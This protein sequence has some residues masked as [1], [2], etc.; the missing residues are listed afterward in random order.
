MSGFRIRRA[1]RRDLGGIVDR[2]LELMAAHQAI[3]PVLYGVA[4]HAEGTYKAFVRRHFDKPDSVVLVAIDPADASVVGYLVGGG[5]QRAPMFLVRRVGMIFDLAVRPDRRRAGIGRALVEHALAHFRERGMHHC[6]VNFDPHNTTAAR[7][8]PDQG[9][10]TLL[11]EA[12][13]PL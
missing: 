11:C 3:D 7:F 8:W 9:F 10:R 5:G 2:W 6:Q 12:Y 1:A 13:R 4:E